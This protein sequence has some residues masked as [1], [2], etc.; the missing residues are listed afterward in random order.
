M[1]K[2]PSD[3][4]MWSVY[5]KSKATKKRMKIN[6]LVCCDAKGNIGKEGGLP[7]DGH[8]VHDMRN[9][10]D[11]TTGNGV[12]MGRKTWESLPERHKPLKGRQNY[13]ISNTLPRE[14]MGMNCSVYPSLDLVIAG[15]KQDGVRELWVIGGE[16]V[17]AEAMQNVQVM[18]DIW[19][20]IVNKVY[21]D[22]DTTFPLSVLHEAFPGGPTVSIPFLTKDKLKYTI[23]CFNNH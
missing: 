12:V 20:T 16:S 1:S 9:F 21:P 18:T 5:R 11:L 3:H 10:T 2:K 6:L 17:Y 4:G 15:A 14:A 13:V 19:V 8:F 7:W 22:C 23:H